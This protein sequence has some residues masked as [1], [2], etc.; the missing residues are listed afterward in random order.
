MRQVGEKS[1]PGKL[2]VKIVVEAADSST[3]N[4]TLKYLRSFPSPKYIAID[5]SDEAGNVELRL[6]ARVTA[7]ALTSRLLNS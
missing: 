2:K 6:L 3:E 1:P 7:L 4:A 5:L